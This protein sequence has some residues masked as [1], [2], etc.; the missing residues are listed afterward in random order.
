LRQ[1]RISPPHRLARSISVVDDA[2]HL[3]TLDLINGK[4]LIEAGNLLGCS[5]SSPQYAWFIWEFWKEKGNQ[6][7]ESF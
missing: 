6:E 7:I 3:D 1:Q 4:K 5:P 2:D